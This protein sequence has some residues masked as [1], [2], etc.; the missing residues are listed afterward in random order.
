M[1][2]DTDAIKGLLPV[3]DYYSMIGY[4]LAKVRAQGESRGEC[5][6]G[7]GCSTRDNPFSI[8]AGGIEWRCNVCDNGGDVI[9]LIRLVEGLDQGQAIA[10][11]AEL[12]G[13]DGEPTREQMDAIERGK[14]RAAELAARD[15]RERATGPARAKRYWLESEPRDE[16]PGGGEDYLDGR[17]VLA[18]R[19]DVRFRDGLICLPLYNDKSEIMNVV[20]RRYSGEGKKITGLSKCGTLGSFGRLSDAENTTGPVIFVEGAFD[21]LAAR[22][23]VPSA[24]VLGAHGA[25]RLKDVVAMGMGVA[26]VRGAVVVPHL[27]DMGKAGAEAAQ[28]AIRAMQREGVS[29]I[30]RFDVPDGDLNDY[31]V[32]GGEGQALL[33][34][35]LVANELVFPETD[36]GNAALLAT[37]HRDDLRYL[38]DVGAWMAWN[39]EHW[40]PARDDVRLVQAARKTIQHIDGEHAVKSQS[41]GAVSAMIKLARAQPELAAV[42]G[43]FDCDDFVL[44]AQNGTLDLRT[45]ELRPFRRDDKI[46]LQVPVPYEPEALAPRWMR[47]LDEIF[48]PAPDARLFVQRFAGYSL[49]GDTSAQC[50]L[51]AHGSGRNG[52]GVFMQIMTALLGRTFAGHLPMRFFV[53]DRPISINVETMLAKVARCRAVFASESKRGQ[54]LDREVVLTMTGEDTLTAR[55]RYQDEFEYTAK[56]KLWM[57]SNNL[58]PI[59]ADDDALWRRFKLVPF[60]AEFDGDKRDDG[61]K[62]TLLTE[63][64]GILAWAV[65]GCLDWQ[66]DGGGMRGLGHSE[67]VAQATAAHR[68]END[69]IGAFLAE[70]TLELL[71]GMPA[72]RSGAVYERYKE[73]CHRAGMKGMSLRYFSKAMAAR[74][75][76]S[77]TEG[78]NRSYYPVALP[79]RD[80]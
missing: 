63:L 12:A 60:L 8:R 25:G 18:A 20:R 22:V 39:G 69:E 52:K 9:E 50:L 54:R 11:A 76:E 78:S 59:D 62:N 26:K 51:F 57:A 3:A 49:T 34:A 32:A 68:E 24:L 31:L 37:L 33:D 66:H 75:L 42:H 70:E 36:L 17:A 1:R 2:H 19:V 53:E 48:E 65:R 5:P 71:P 45:G 14:R 74:D 27:T 6:L 41:A 61:L 64:P 35:P 29:S 79:G 55:R 67:A 40:E 77:Y 30:R 56:F 7:N 16:S 47:F 73:W 4:S 10:R 15:E 28:E 46:S 43:D 44:C 80:E 23:L 72:A 38:H 58:P 13:I 21:Y